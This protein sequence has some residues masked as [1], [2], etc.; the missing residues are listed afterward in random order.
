MGSPIFF[1]QVRPGLNASLFQ[2][3]KFRTMKH[4]NDSNGQPLPDE[5]RLT[6]LGTFLRSTSLDELP[7]LVLVFTG[8]MSLVGPRPLLLEYLP[9]YSKEQNKRHKVRP[10]ITGLA[11][12]KGRNAIS[13]SE[14]LEYDVN[15]VD[16]YSFRLDICILI[17]TFVV[18]FKREGIDYSEDIKNKKFPGN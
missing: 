16:N 11:Q 10:G 17:R 8:K 1:K 2:M 6:K 4:L 15:Y 7:E 14:R 5:E 3:I 13:W 18:V 9:L 12:I